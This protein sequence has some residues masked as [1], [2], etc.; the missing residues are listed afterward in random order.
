[1]IGIQATGKTQILDVPNKRGQMWHPVGDSIARAASNEDSGFTKPFVHVFFDGKDELEQGVA[2]V[3]R[4]TRRYVQGLQFNGL[5]W[6]DI[7]YRPFMHIFNEVYPSQS[8]ILQAGSNTLNSHSPS[9]LAD[10]IETMPVDYLLLDPSGG[11]GKQMDSTRIRNYV[12]EIYQSQI[13]VG[14]ALSGGLD[15]KNVEELIGPLM[16]DYPDLSC[17]AEGRL[18]KGPEGSTV[19][20]IEAV[21]AYLVACKQT[22]QRHS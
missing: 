7:D 10:G 22:I 9:E 19:I 17:D 12:D 18:R 8:T 21:D 5:A 11:E 6:L 20:D 15:A 14:V 1:M 13:P 3:M 16:E 4:R 2:N